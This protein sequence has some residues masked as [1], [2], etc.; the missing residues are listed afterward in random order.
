MVHSGTMTDDQYPKD[1]VTKAILRWCHLSDSAAMTTTSASLAQCQEYGVPLQRGGSGTNEGRL[2][3]ASEASHRLRHCSTAQR[4]LLRAKYWDGNGHRPVLRKVATGGYEVD[5]IRACYCSDRD[6]ARVMG[7]SSS[8]V[9]AA[10][11][12]A[13]RRAVRQGL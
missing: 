13:A 11:I 1:P 6:V 2:I 5:S 4:A 7:L 10:R 12:K 8:S 3:A 9:A